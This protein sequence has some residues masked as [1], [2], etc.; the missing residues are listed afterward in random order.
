MPWLDMVLVVCYDDA[1]CNE[2]RWQIRMGMVNRN[3]SV[4]FNQ[5]WL[6]HK[7]QDVHACTA[8]GFLVRWHSYSTA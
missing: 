3:A 2:E 8:C 4:H 7:K 1:S 6:L 5:I